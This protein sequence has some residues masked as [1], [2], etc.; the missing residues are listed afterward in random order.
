[1]AAWGGMQA[2]ASACLG[3]GTEYWT[4][5]RYSVTAFSQ[6]FLSLYQA[7]VLNADELDGIRR[8]GLSE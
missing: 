7:N 5:S 4:M 1:M 2:S 6:E 3:M 8:T